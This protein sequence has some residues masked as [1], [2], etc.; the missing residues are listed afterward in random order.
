MQDSV[1]R[2]LGCARIA[3]RNSRKNRIT[4]LKDLQDWLEISSATMTNWKSRGVSKLG[5]LKAEEV[6]G[7][8]PLFILEGSGSPFG[9][10][11]PEEFWRDPVASLANLDLWEAHVGGSTV[12]PADQAHPGMFFTPRS[13]VQQLQRILRQHDRVRRGQIGHLIDQLVEDPESPEVI[14]ALVAEVE[15]PPSKQ[16]A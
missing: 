6:I 1:T 10:K 15:R 12:P 13:L 4:D 11:P 7:C 9:D 16:A 3:T 14:R 2:L 5:A 8:K